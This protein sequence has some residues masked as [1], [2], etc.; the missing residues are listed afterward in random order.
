VGCASE[1]AQHEHAAMLKV[2]AAY[3]D[4]AASAQRAAQ[5]L[6]ADQ[7]HLAVRRALTPLSSRPK[8]RQRRS[9]FNL[10]RLVRADISGPRDVRAGAMPP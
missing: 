2:A 3:E 4:V 9:R 1:A 10:T 6:D 7:E 5:S 8:V